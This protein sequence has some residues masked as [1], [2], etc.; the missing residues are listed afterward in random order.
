M[1]FIKIQNTQAHNFEKQ[2]KRH[3]RFA[4]ITKNKHDKGKNFTTD[5]LMILN[6]GGGNTTELSCHNAHKSSGAMGMK[7]VFEELMKCEE[8]IEK[9]CN[10]NA[11]AF[12]NI[13]KVAMLPFHKNTLSFFSGGRVRCNYQTFW[14]IC[15]DL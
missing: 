14:G 9:S 12:S 8:D 3:G 4:D 13:T 6:A 10:Y 5:A 2:F 11:I 15:S 1:N 7:S